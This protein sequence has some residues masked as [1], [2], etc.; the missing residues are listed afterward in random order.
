MQVAILRISRKIHR[1]MGAFL[2]LFFFIIA[3]TGLLLGWKKNSNG[4]ILPETT[5]GI[6]T[7]FDNWKTTKELLK[8]SDSILITKVDKSLSTKLDRIDIRKDKGIVKFI[9]T[10]DYWEIQLDGQ[11]GNVLRISQRRSDFIEDIHDGSFLDYYFKND[12][13]YIKLIYTSIMGLSLFLFTVTGFWLWFGP[14]LIR[15]KKRK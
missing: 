5:K 15:N 4:W 9:Y 1:T 12:G 10:Y 11:S 2:F 6:S 13:E 8:I 3:I 7:N 14:K